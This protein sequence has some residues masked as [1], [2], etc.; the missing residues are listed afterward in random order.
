MKSLQ[1][2]D[3]L[4]CGG[5]AF[6]LIASLVWSSLWMESKRISARDARENLLACRKLAAEIRSRQGAPSR[7]ALQAS[8]TAEVT[9]L[10]EQAASSINLPGSSVSVIEPQV[11]RRFADS[12]Y[13]VQ[14][15]RIQLNP[16]SLH[17]IVSLLHTLAQ[18]QTGLVVVRLLLS[19]P[20]RTVSHDEK[21]EAWLTELTL[22]KLIYDPILRSSR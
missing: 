12:P 17:Y 18:D 9:R 1:R 8:S 15:T 22:T 5:G 14:E 21:P 13:K 10:L 7:A 2:L 4:V 6:L 19:D 16:L 20:T 3:V 11:P